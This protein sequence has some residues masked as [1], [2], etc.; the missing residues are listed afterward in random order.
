MRKTKFDLM[1]K[2][3]KIGDNLHYSWEIEAQSNN[4][5]LSSLKDVRTFSLKNVCIL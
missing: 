2:D 1:K 5:F 3:K 4:I